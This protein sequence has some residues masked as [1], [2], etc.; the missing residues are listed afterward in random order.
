MRCTYCGC[1]LEKDAKFCN[2][3]GKP[4]SVRDEEMINTNIN[5]R[6]KKRNEEISFVEVVGIIITFLGVAAM[7]FS[8]IK[9]LADMITM[10]YVD[11][12]FPLS[13][14]HGEAEHFSSFV[15]SIAFSILGIIIWVV[16]R[17]VR[18]AE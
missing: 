2:A 4:V 13:D 11:Y 15:T 3:C 12:T 17:N 16:G 10:P 7:A 8:L 18:K 14:K 9:I 6:K 1:E 5:Q